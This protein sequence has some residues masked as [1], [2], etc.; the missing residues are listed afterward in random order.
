MEYQKA[1]EQIENFINAINTIKLEA[2]NSKINKD[3]RAKADN[4]V[5][6]LQQEINRL[7]QFER[8][9]NLLNNHS[10]IKICEQCDG[11]GGG[12]EGDDFS[13]YQQWECDVCQ[14]KGIL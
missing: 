1:K 13:G 14:G 11:H 10:N 5:L 8:K 2:S 9:F 4:K 7:K 6:E 12:V 3:A